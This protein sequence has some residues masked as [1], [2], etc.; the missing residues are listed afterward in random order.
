MYARN[1]LLLRLRNFLCST[2]ARRACTAISVGVLLGLGGTGIGDTTAEEKIKLADHMETG[3]F[4][5]KEAFEMEEKSNQKVRARP[6]LI[7]EG[8]SW[9]DLPMFHADISDMLERIENEDKQKYAIIS[10]ADRGDTLENMAFNRQLPEM[11]S[12]FRR[13]REYDKGP[14]AIL[15]STGGN[16]VMGPALASLVN[17]RHSSLGKKSLWNDDIVNAAFH[18]FQTYMVEYVVAISLL[19]ER[20]FPAN[21]AASANTHCGRIP[22]IVHGYDYPVPSGKGFK[23]LWLFKLKGPWLKPIF[24]T[25]MHGRAESD[26]IIEYLVDQYNDRLK[27]AV[28]VLQDGYRTKQMANPVCY[29]NLRNTVKDT[30]WADELHPNRA[31]MRAIAQQFIAEIDRCGSGN[32]Y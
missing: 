21:G 18:R 28:E 24:D 12:Q 8:D 1:N 32:S 25:K 11:A 4:L 14:A 29:L 17:H 5:A 22:I 16:D 10:I 3:I 9:F 6:V 27:S 20:Y 23:F 26:D 31:G 2:E 15:L 7:L 30:Q 19:C 13:L